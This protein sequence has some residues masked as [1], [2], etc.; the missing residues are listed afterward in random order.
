MAKIYQVKTIEYETKDVFTLTLSQQDGSPSAPF[1]PGQF[2]MIYQFGFGEAAM[3]ISGNPAN[4]HEL[5]HTVRAVGSVTKSLQKM[6]VGDQIGVRGPFGRPW[7]FEMKACDV[8]V[9]AGGVGLAPLRSAIYQLLANRG[10]YQ[11]ICLLYGARSPE[12]IIY[13]KDLQQW[14][15]QGLDVKITLDH[16]NMRWKG[17]V[18]VVTT[19]IQSQILNPKNTLVFACGPEIMLKFAVPELLSAMVPENNIFLSLE[20]NMQCAE[21]FCGHCL[22]GP[23]FLCKDGPV[24][25]YSDLKPWFNINEL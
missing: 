10:D 23:Y 3:S 13:A 20:R 8:L 19:F 11:K 21:G 15:N 16:A 14:E 25:S 17:H 24:F 5:I 1:L 2:N 7:P 18:G 9:I 22:Y 6:K 4:Q 12:E